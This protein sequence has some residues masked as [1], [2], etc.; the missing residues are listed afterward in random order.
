MNVPLV[1]R[2][3]LY[4]KGKLVISIASI[5]AALA[6]ILLLLGFRAGLY[7]TLTAFVD[8]I[9]ADVIVAQNGTQGMLTSNSIVPLNLHDEAAATVKAQEAGHIIVAGTIFTYNDNKTPVLLVG[10]DPFTPLG[11]PWNIGQGRG[12]QADNEILLDTWLAQRNG[13]AV[14]DSVHI[15]GQRF[16]IVGLTRETA[17]WMSPYIFVSLGAAASVL[18]LSNMVSYHLLRLPPGLEASQAIK[19]IEQGIAGIDA[20]TPQEIAEADQRVL[21][22]IMDTPLNV[23][24]VIGLVI[25]VAVMGLTAYTAVMDHLQEYG[26]LKAVGISGWRLSWLVI[27]ETFYRAMLGF[28]TGIGLAYAAAALIMT[29]WPQFTIVIQ[30]QTIVQAG[31]LTLIMTFL[32]VWLPIQ[33]LNQID[34]LLVFKQ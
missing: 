24:I 25:G 19:T 10:Y 31:W 20:L 8:H 18:G 15:L 16:V 11:Q 28:V 22:T 5:A 1:W 7:V 32:A 33:R 21:A 23:M 29:L 4:E 2:N 6:L 12:V 26:V 27:V 3:L 30:P 17:S 34:P 13:L 14:G 9:G